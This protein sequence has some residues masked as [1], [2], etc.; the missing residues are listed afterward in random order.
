[1]RASIEGNFL[2]HRVRGETL[3]HDI[4]QL[5]MLLKNL[6][7]IKESD[8]ANLQEDVDVLFQELEQN[9]I[10]RL[11]QS[12]KSVPIAAPESLPS[13]TPAPVVETLPNQVTDWNIDHVSLWL[14][15]NEF[16]DYVGTF[17]ENQINGYVCSFV[18][19]K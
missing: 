1:M 8:F 5:L 6:S 9:K 17:K 4:G 14:S 2:Y 16:G 10:Q 12:G 3:D 7:D 13:I 19:P 11:M 18:Q 15:Q